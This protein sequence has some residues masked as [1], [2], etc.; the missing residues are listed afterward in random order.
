MPLDGILLK[1][2]RKD[3]NLWQTIE[4]LEVSFTDLVIP[5]KCNFNTVKF[6]KLP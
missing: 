6:R 3:E 1:I 5:E 2:T 4:I